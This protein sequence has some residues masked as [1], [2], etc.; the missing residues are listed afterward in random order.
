MSRPHKR[1]LNTP[2]RRGVIDTSWDKYA[3]EFADEFPMSERRRRWRNFDPV[4]RVMDA[5]VL[6]IVMTRAQTWRDC[7]RGQCKRAKACIGPKIDC[8]WLRLPLMQQEGVVPELRRQIQV[9]V[10]QR[11]ARE[12]AA[13]AAG[14]S[15]AGRLDGAAGAGAQSSMEDNHGQSIRS[16]R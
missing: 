8:F 5:R 2:P 14:A 16:R 12:A 9:Y 7:P 6:Q 11:E 13:A 15:P 1:K 10:A 4:A 3:D